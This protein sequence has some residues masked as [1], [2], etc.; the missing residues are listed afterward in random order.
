MCTVICLGLLLSNVL[1]VRHITVHIMFIKQV[2]SIIII[3]SNQPTQSHSDV[4]SK[5][6]FDNKNF[7]TFNA[8]SIGKQFVKYSTL[9]TEVEHDKLKQ[10]L[11][12]V[13]LA[14]DNLYT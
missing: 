13:L 11:T 9:L 5:Q 7:L 10:C 12:A 8:I 1:N 3:K 4:D 14:T 2:Q 6:D